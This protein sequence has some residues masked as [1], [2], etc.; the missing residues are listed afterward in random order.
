MWRHCNASWDEDIPLQCLLNFNF[1]LSTD[2]FYSWKIYIVC[3][4]HFA[5]RPQIIDCDHTHTHTD[6]YI[7]IYIYIYIL[8]LKK[9]KLKSF[10]RPW[11][12]RCNT[13]RQAVKTWLY[14]QTSG[15]SLT[16]WR[17]PFCNYKHSPFDIYIY[18]YIYK[19]TTTCTCISPE[20]GAKA[21]RLWGPS[22]PNDRWSQ[23]RA[24]EFKF[25]VWSSMA[26]WV[27]QR[28]F[29]LLAI[30]CLRPWVRILHSPE[31]YKLS[32]LDSKIACLC[33]SIEINNKHIYIYIL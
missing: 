14:P 8:L 26:H 15:T 13:N 7:Y 6:I 20:P 29:S 10:V 1:I 32:P 11:F 4:L 12:H 2:F 9:S 22:G 31:E 17:Q 18:I 19:L 5:T 33:Q 28:A 30:W 16:S 25:L 27:C 21:N 3:E 24:V 23:G